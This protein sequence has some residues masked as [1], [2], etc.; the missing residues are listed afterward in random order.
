[1]TMLGIFI[2][3]T[4]LP[5]ML[6]LSLIESSLI[7]RSNEEIGLTYLQKYGYLNTDRG[8]SLLNFNYV[9]MKLHSIN[10]TSA[11]SLLK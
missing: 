6:Y 7:G 9:S 5:S 11:V 1:M 3:I 10:S 4:V 2:L 8:K